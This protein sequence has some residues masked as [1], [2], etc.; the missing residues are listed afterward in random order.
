MSGTL[1]PSSP[2]DAQIDRGDAG[3]PESAPGSSS[4]AGVSHVQPVR[5]EEREAASRRQEAR[6]LPAPQ[7]AT[8]VTVAAPSHAGERRIIIGR[9]EVEVHNEP[10]S[11][12]HGATRRSEPSAPRAGLASRFL[13][14]P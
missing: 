12:A 9:I 4:G 7:P 11:A 3:S 13:M 14:K 1:V 10:P 8:T 5:R 6:L 2:L